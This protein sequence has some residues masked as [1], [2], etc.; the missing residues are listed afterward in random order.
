VSNRITDRCDGS[1]A[2]RGEERHPS[3]WS[4]RSC[5]A[6]DA[7]NMGDVHLSRQHG[8]RVGIAVALFGIALLAGGW[9]LVGLL[10][11]SLTLPG[12]AR[13]PLSEV[14]DRSPSPIY[15]LGPAVPPLAGDHA[16]L[17]IDVIG[18]DEVKQLL[19]LRLSGYRTCGSTC[20]AEELVLVSVRADE[21]N[22]PGLPP[23]AT[24][25]LPAHDGLV[26]A[27]IELPVQGQL[28]QYPFD[29]FDL[30]LG[31]ALQE[32]G[33]DAATRPLLATEATSHLRLTLREE[34]AQLQW[35][36]PVSVD[37]A[38]FQSAT[39]PSTTSRFRS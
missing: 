10:V 18:L 29:S 30:L 25:P 1:Y 6:I 39:C 33:T 8:L 38:P 23:L 4:W 26:E 19:T 7:S 34:I 5:G 22:R 16:D 37:P 28:L 9:T 14:F 15:A 13:P 3:A 17:R 11:P 27:T 35:D 21:S 24:V 2:A 36:A 20:T 12:G 32:V 31:V